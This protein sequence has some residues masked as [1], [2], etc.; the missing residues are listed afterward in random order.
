MTP[1]LPCVNVQQLWISLRSFGASSPTGHWEFH[2][3]SCVVARISNRAGHCHCRLC[4]GMSGHELVMIQPL[5]DIRA[6]ILRE[7]HVGEC[8]NILRNKLEI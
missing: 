2:H 1:G 8:D 4:E 5:S 7:L 6:W 3:Q